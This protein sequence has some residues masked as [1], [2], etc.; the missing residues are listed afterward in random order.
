MLISARGSP[1]K[2]FLP[3]VSLYTPVLQLK[4]ENRLKSILRSSELRKRVLLR[5]REEKVVKYK[6]VAFDQVT[7]KNIM[8]QVRCHD[9]FRLNPLPPSLCPLTKEHKYEIPVRPHLF[10]DRDLQRDLGWAIMALSCKKSVLRKSNSV[11]T[12]PQESNH[13]ASE[14]SSVY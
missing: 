5:K 4:E 3:S 12:L 2:S 14:A 9:N 10:I 7:F 13:Y 8:W 11:V 1:A 6:S